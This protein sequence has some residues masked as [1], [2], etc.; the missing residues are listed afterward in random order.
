MALPRQFNS[1]TVGK[2]SPAATKRWKLIIKDQ[3]IQIKLDAN[4]LRF[5]WSLCEYILLRIIRK[6]LF[7]HA[8]LERFGACLPY[9]ELNTSLA[10]PTDI[11]NRYV[12]LLG[13]EIEIP[14]KNILEI[15]PGPTNSVGYELAALGAGTVWAFEPHWRLET[16]TDEKFLFSSAKKH[17]LPPTKLKD[18]VRRVKNL[19]D[20]PNDSVDIILSNSVLE[21]VSNLNS[22]SSQC[23]QKCKAGGIMGQI[24]DLR[25]HFFKYPY[26]FLTFKKKTWDRF[27]NPG[28][29]PRW[30]LNDIL[31][32]LSAAKFSNKIIEFEKSDQEFAKIKPYVSSDFN[33]MDPTLAVMRASIKSTK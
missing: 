24:V 11:A 12:K 32:A 27:L 3:N 29:L 16:R 2:G 10:N 23:F 6:F 22:L 25:D 5:R 19:S 7:P 21:H 14:G 20:I 33:S 15:G 9:Y 17:N 31:S 28:D 26:H 18:I 4:N 13:D 8:I 30:R 1:Q